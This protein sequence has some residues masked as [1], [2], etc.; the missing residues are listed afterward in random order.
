MISSGCGSAPTM[1]IS[2]CS[3]RRAA[4]GV[5]HSATFTPMR[6]RVWENAIAVPEAAAVLRE[7]GGIIQ[8]FAF[9]AE[10]FEVYSTMREPEQPSR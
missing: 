7:A 5:E 6:P 4:E 1:S 8:P 10:K 2:A 3:S 9:D